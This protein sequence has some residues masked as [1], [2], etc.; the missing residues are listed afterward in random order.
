MNKYMLDIDNKKEQNII[1]M[2]KKSRFI[3]KA[4]SISSKEEAD[5]IIENTRNEHKDARHVVYAYILKNSGKYS[6][7]KEPFGTAGSPIYTLLKNEKLVNVMIVVI[8]Y[9]G[10][11][12]L[13]KGLLT[14]TYLKAAIQAINCY[15]KKEYINYINTNISFT[16]KEEKIIQKL[17]KQTNSN[18]L[19]TIRDS[20][21]QMNISIP[22]INIE[23][24]L[25]YIN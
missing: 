13:G 20:K 9:F 5:K 2:E 10:G 21:V 15:G 24:F 8:R 16:Y 7:D 12:L 23:L 4:F 3:A 14:R 17:I 18:I 22:D 6:D 25:K 1:I 11:V 19:N